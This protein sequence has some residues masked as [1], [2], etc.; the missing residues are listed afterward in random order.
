MRPLLLSLLLLLSGCS[1]LH[2]PAPVGDG[3]TSTSLNTAAVEGRAQV[4]DKIAG[5]A[6]AAKKALDPLPESRNK[7]VANGFLDDIV[8]LTGAPTPQTK[9]SFELLATQLLSE[10]AAQRAKAEAQWAKVA[11]DNDALKAKVSKL[12]QDYQAA[13]AKER[14]D[15]KIELDAA[16]K[17][18][19][20]EAAAK[21]RLLITSI[22]MGGG[23]LLV[24]A[25]VLCFFLAGSNPL[26]GPKVAIGLVA[27]G[28]LGI[29]TGVAVLQLM[30]HPNV[31]WWGLGIIVAVLA[32]VA[33]LMISNHHHSTETTTNG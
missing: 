33:G 30:T 21:E 31:V 15:A 11:A 1:L 18:A 10:D 16:V 4:N 22:F 24:A 32:G 3:K 27:A 2:S 23:G 14:A 28:M 8:H 13:L 9:T 26:L 7:D 5:D 6:V 20:D 12:E 17:K 19:R 29:F 25:G